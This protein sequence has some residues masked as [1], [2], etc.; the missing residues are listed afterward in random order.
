MRS[1]LR[2]PPR[3]GVGLWAC[4]PAATA[5]PTAMTT[6]RRRKGRERRIMMS[7]RG[8]LAE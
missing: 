4:T 6:A 3:F 2:T 8:F 7:S 5:S 1:V